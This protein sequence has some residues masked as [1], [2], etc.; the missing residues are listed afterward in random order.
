MAL[1]SP[2]NL[3]RA[4]EILCA[5]ADKGQRCPPASGHAAHSFLKSAHTSAL[6]KQGKIRIEVFAHN[7]RVITIL[8]GPHKGKHTELSPYAGA[9]KPYQIIDARGA[10]FTGRNIPADRGAQR[11]RQPWS[12]PRLGE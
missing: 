8:V 9:K 11:R 10:V 4:F 5:C 1:T 2:E 6:A 3:D 12:P 7:W